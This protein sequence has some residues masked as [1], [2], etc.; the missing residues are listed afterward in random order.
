MSW[1]A[2]GGVPYSARFSR[3]AI[4]S[5]HLDGCPARRP[6]KICTPTPNIAD[7]NPHYPTV[8]SVCLPISCNPFCFLYLVLFPVSCFVSSSLFYFLY[9]ILFPAFS[10]YLS[11]SF[12]LSIRLRRSYR[13]QAVVGKTCPDISLLVT[14]LPRFHCDLLLACWGAWRHWS[15]KR[16]CKSNTREAVECL[17]L[18]PVC[19]FIEGPDGPPAYVGCG[20]LGGPKFALPT[21]PDC[22]ACQATTDSLASI[23]QLLV[24]PTAAQIF[25]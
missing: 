11:S 2:F 12:L 18:D 21:Q 10:F 4:S 9:L 23:D 3:M 5:V 19:P 13:V 25:I 1:C 17:L 24:C 6:N 14:C 20:C 15:K 7:R 16:I 22:R 8:L